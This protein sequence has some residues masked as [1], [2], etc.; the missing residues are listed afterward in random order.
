MSMF[1]ATM[2]A[3]IVTML[4]ALM[5]TALL[6]LLLNREAATRTVPPLPMTDSDIS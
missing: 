3:V 2:V 4:L 1:A 5:C 6:P